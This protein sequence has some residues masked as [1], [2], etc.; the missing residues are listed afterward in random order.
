KNEK[1]NTEVYNI[2]GKYFVSGNVV[3]G[4]PEV[5]EDNWDL[6]VFNQMKPSYNVTQADKNSI[7]IDQPHDIQNNVVTDSPK[8]AYEKILKIGGASLVRDAVDLHI[9]K[10]VKS[11]SFTY[12]GSKGSSNGIIDSQNDVGGFPDLK[13]GKVL[14]DS[15]NDGMPDEWEI[16]NKLDPKKANANGRDLNKDYDNIEV[17]THDIVKH[18]T[19]GQL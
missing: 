4:S 11:G 9:I 7:K 17:Y 10:D 6:G 5:T 14:L 18:I 8:M 1:P 16:K 2:W 12:N 19:K 13:P 15:D 3:E